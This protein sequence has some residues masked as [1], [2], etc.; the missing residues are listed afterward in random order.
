MNNQNNNSHCGLKVL[1][2]AFFLLNVF[3]GV[4]D[5][6]QAISANSVK[7]LKGQLDPGLVDLHTN[8]SLPHVNSLSFYAN[9]TSDNLTPFVTKSNSSVSRQDIIAEPIKIKVG[10][11]LDQI[12][13]INQKD[14]N[15]DV[16]A[17]IQMQ[18][19]NPSLGFSPE[20]CN[21]SF[22]IYRS[23][24]Q[25]MQEYGSAFPEFTIFNQQGNRWTQ[26]EIIIVQPNGT[27]TYF[28]RFWVKLQAPD[29][30][31]RKYPLD[32][33]DFY[34]LIDSLYPEDYYAYEIWPEKTKIGTQLGEEEWYITASD[35]NVSSVVNQE[36]NSRS[37]F[38]IQAQRHLSY[39]AL[40]ILF[41]IIV[42][43][44]I[45]W[46]TLFLKDYGKRADIAGGNLLLFIAFNF[47]I[48]S[49]LP[50][51][52]YLTFLDWIMFFTFIL[53]ALMFIYNIALKLLESR[54]KKE[55][56]EHIDRIMIWLYP[57]LYFTA[58]YLVPLFFYKHS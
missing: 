2:A 35:A 10:V 56:A 47:T 45:S 32:S 39:Y 57:P 23:I 48:A 1:I 42:I 38:H 43:V 8:S 6:C 15:F 40:R 30:D 36:A 46:V 28:E 49:D 44:L 4:L 51:L 18:W 41:P 5:T 31:F 26:N 34:I 3:S 27:A 29:F 33:Q 21:C 11:E 17:A 52:G 55:M 20:Q 13:A 19:V 12:S 22:K 7:D 58:S 9:V 53:T 37:S 16:V 54:D 14:Q 24:D 25:F 50:R